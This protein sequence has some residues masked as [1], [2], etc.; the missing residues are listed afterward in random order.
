M[1]RTSIVLFFCILFSL[2]ACAFAPVNKPEVDL[3]KN[4][5]HADFDLPM[6]QAKA[7]A[8]KTY[9]I[10]GYQKKGE[11]QK[12][13]SLLIATTPKALPSVGNCSCGTWNGSKVQG[14]VLSIVAIDL[15]PVSAQKTRVSV[16]VLYI[17]KFTGHNLYGATTRQEVVKCQSTGKKERQ[18]I[19]IMTRLANKPEQQNGNTAGKVSQ[20]AK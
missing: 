15:A 14:D 3:E 1:K 11:N 20:Q 19:E 7:L 8:E 2:S 10:M 12:P 18:F 6:D 16:K 17:T 5:A 4:M 9:D 13:D